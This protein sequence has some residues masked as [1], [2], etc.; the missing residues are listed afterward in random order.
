VHITGEGQL[1]ELIEKAN[2]NKSV[3]A[4]RLNQHSSRS[5]TLFM[6]EL[7]QR[8]S[9]GGEVAGKLNLVDLAGSEK[10]SKSGAVG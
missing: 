2:K 1:F 5:H 6:L 10:V 4:T 7:V 9:L 3:R 8:T